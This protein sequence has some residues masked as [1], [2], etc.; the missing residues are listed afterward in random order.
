M[1]I[2]DMHA[3]ISAFLEPQAEQELALRKQND[4]ITCFSSGT[5]E[6]WRFMQTFKERPE[7]RLSFGLH[8]WYA[9]QWTIEECMP[10]LEQCDLIGEIGMDSVWCSVSLE[11][12]QRQLEKQLQLAADQKKPVILHTKGQEERIADLLQ[13]FPERICVH[14]YSGPEKTLE[15]YMALDCYFTLGPDTARLAEA[16]AYLQQQMLREIPA[17]RLFV[18]TDGI[19]AVAWA[20]Q[21]ETMEL[22]QIPAVLMENLAYAAK[23]KGQTP[24]AL[25]RQM[26]VNLER[27]LS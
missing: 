15:R 19:E 2:I 24:E 17:E 25:A 16:G 20:M 10:A 18:E 27:F 3:H 23:Q 4:L 1:Q 14:W 7:L 6:E 13:G 8:P 11:V 21:K 9:D 22:T 12:Q 5:P 26:R